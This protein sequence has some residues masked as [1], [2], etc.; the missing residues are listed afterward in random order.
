MLG[1]TT[2]LP[3][4]HILKLTGVHSNKKKIIQIDRNQ[5]MAG[6]F[7]VKLKKSFWREQ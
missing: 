1:N 3:V 5:G 4:L 6:W 2:D 7:L